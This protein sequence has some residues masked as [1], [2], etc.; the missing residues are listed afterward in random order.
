MR[1]RLSRC[2]IPCCLI[3]LAAHAALAQRPSP[4][5]SGSPSPSASATPVVG[6]VGTFWTA[7]LP[8]GTYTVIHD[9]VASISWH[10]Y[11]LEGGASRVSEVCIDTRGSA[12]ARF[13]VIEPATVTTSGPGAS[14]VNFLEEKA[15]EAQQR[16][17]AGA[18]D[19]WQKVIKTYP[20]T[21][22]AHTVEYR[23]ES[24]EMLRRLF[25]NAQTSWMRRKNDTFKP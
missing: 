8:A 17:T 7:E 16:V 6:A 4:G 12:I 10:E 3:L 19:V 14:T 23:L 13:Y 24:R 25:E 20:V 11:T 22:H 1:F 15:R 9:A 5:A 18:S 2:V 21:T